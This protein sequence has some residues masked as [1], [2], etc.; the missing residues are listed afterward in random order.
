MERDCGLEDSS[1]PATEL[2][3]HTWVCPVLPVPRRMLQAPFPFFTLLISSTGTK[4]QEK[5]RKKALQRM[6]HQVAG[7]S[8]GDAMGLQNLADVQQV[9]FV[10]LLTLQQWECWKLS[11]LSSPWLPLQFL[12]LPPSPRTEKPSEPSVRAT[13]P[14]SSSSWPAVRYRSLLSS[15][16]VAPT[17]NSTSTC[18]ATPRWC[19]HYYR[20]WYCQEDGYC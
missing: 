10:F 9:W 11:M 13:H 2:E 19:C 15:T 14:Y 17:Y 5:E 4:G 1:T 18:S 7:L 8:S 20:S 12:S 16:R 6:T 3:H